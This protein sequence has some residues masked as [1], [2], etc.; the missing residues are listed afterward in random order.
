MSVTKQFSRIPIK[1]IGNGLLS[2]GIFLSSYILGGYSLGLSVL[3]GAGC[4]AGYRL[5]FGTDLS[6]EDIW[7]DLDISTAE[8]A[9]S[10]ITKARAYM[11]EIQE[12]NE[13]IPSESLTEKLNKLEE[14]GLKIIEL[15][16]QDPRDISRSKRFIEV[17]LSGSVSVSRKFAEL[18]QKT[19]NDELHQQ[20]EDFLKDMV[21]TFEKQYHALLDHDLIDLDVEIDVLKQRMKSEAYYER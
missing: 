5:L 3:L 15:F 1:E 13:A 19:N 21:N 20:Y 11:R 7:K 6:K 16:E 9:L 8:I 12:L 4:Y 2:S 14:L 18:H 17:Y 10:Q